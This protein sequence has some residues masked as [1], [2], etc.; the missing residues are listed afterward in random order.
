MVTPSPPDGGGTEGD[1]MVIGSAADF[2]G[3]IVVGLVIIAAVLAC[4]VGG[5]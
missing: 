3:P 2:W 5:E 4:F 1:I